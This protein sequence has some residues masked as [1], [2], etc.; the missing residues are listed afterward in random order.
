MIGPFIALLMSAQPSPAQMYHRPVGRC[1]EA[2]TDAVSDLGTS[3]HPA[4]NRIDF[5]ETLDVQGSR[6]TIL[7]YKFSS[8]TG[9]R[10]VT[11]KAVVDLEI[12]RTERQTPW[13]LDLTDCRVRDAFILE[14]TEGAPR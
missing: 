2:V 11:G 10:A 7:Y 14:E 1:L 9:R 8:G 13:L 4:D 12:L 5:E 6:Y 3:H